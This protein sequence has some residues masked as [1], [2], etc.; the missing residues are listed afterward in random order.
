MKGRRQEAVAN[1]RVRGW[2]ADAEEL[3][4][5]EHVL[6]EAVEVV[7][8]VLGHELHGEAKNA[9]TNQDADGKAFGKNVHL[10]HGATEHGE[11]ERDDEGNGHDG[12]GELQGDEKSLAGAG[13]DVGGEDFRNVRAADGQE[14]VGPLEADEQPV[15]QVQA[16][17]EHGGEEIED[18]RW[19]GGL[20]AAH[21]IDVGGER[22]AD[23]GADDDAGDVQ[24]E[25]NHA[26]GEAEHEAD[27]NLDGHDA[28]QS[29]EIT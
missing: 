19:R 18:G 17:P 9:Q 1:E 2:S 28:D 13:D 12:R 6:G 8:D 14:A 3:G 7:G 21:G 15:V 4:D 23:F 16:Q 26:G 11:D 5:L 10:G 20:G 24:G 29:P 25:E 22:Q 27:T